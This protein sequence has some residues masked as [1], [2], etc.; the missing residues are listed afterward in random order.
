MSALRSLQSI[1]RRK[2]HLEKQ[3]SS[4]KGFSILWVSVF[5]Q[6]AGQVAHNR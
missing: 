3:R 1:A 6:D 2:C 4:G 5:C